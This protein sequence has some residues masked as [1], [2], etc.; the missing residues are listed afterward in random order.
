MA[1]FSKT[2][3]THVLFLSTEMESIISRVSIVILRLQPCFLSGR[4]HLPLLCLSDPM[5]SWEGLCLIVKSMFFPILCVPPTTSLQKTNEATKHPGSKA[6]T[7]QEGCGR[8]N[9][10]Q[11]LPPRN[12][13]RTGFKMALTFWRSTLKAPMAVQSYDVTDSLISSSDF[14]LDLNFSSSLEEN[15]KS[16]GVSQYH[17]DKS[18]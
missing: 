13:E 5:E 17:L 10:M 2:Q 11:W 4:T 14:S 12:K 9:K 7:C 3:S 6:E 16:N 1:V 15:C 8:S 18:M